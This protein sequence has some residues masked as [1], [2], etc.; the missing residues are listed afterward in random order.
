MVFISRSEK[1]DLERI[2][3]RLKNC[4][5]L[6]ISDMENFARKGGVVHL[7][8]AGNK[9]RFAINVDAAERNGLQVSSK[10]LKLAKIVKSNG[11][12]EED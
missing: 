8:P 7:F 1:N 6:T 12:G 9:I 11:R 5:V 2:F 3:V 4:N 10:L